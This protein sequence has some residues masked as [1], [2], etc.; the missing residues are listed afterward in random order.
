MIAV[1]YVGLDLCMNVRL[2]NGKYSIIIIEIRF[3]GRFANEA[4]HGI[5]DGT[6]LHLLLVSL[7]QSRKQLLLR[8][9]Q[10]REVLRGLTRLQPHYLWLTHLLITQFLQDVVCVTAHEETSQRLRILDK[11]NVFLQRIFL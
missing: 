7:Q 1:G 3:L 11:T 2:E 6:E 10:E 5:H 4:L 8:L 9:I